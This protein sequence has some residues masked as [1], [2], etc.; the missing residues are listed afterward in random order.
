MSQATTKG[1]FTKVNKE[2]CNML[3]YTEAGMLETSFPDITYPEDRE[4]GLLQ[5]KKMM[6]GEL[7]SFQ[8]EKRYVHKNGS[9]VWASIVVTM[10]FDD[11]RVPLYIV[12]QK[13][14]IT[15]NKQLERDLMLS[16]KEFRSAFEN[17]AIG[18]A[19]VSAEG[20]FIKVNPELCKMLGYPEKE[21]VQITFPEIT[22]PDDLADNVT[23]LKRLFS[24]EIQL[25][26]G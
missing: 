17:S 13:K 21:L 1:R 3:G 26:K 20:R 23:N 16:E 2:F 7:E 6:N 10:V 18:M 22:H 15:R 14:D 9:I 5:L 25:Y 24:G 12:S 19:L 4:I 11:N 8:A